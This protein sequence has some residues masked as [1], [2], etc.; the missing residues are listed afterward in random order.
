[1]LQNL[2]E[3]SHS[4]ADS[5]FRASSALWVSQSGP[6]RPKAVST[7]VTHHPRVALLSPALE[8]PH[9]KN[10]EAPSCS[11]DGRTGRN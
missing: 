11:A 2:E 9:L 6:R 3:T 8:T 10:V 5:A 1:M 4:T 7:G